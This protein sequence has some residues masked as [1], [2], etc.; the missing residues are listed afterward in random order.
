MSLNCTTTCVCPVTG[1]DYISAG[2]EDRDCKHRNINVERRGRAHQSPWQFLIDRGNGIESPAHGN[3]REKLVLDRANLRRMISGKASTCEAY[4][5]A[6]ESPISRQ[7]PA[8]TSHP[9]AAA[10]RSRSDH[11]RLSAFSYVSR[12]SLDSP[13]LSMVD[14]IGHSRPPLD[15]QRR[16]KAG[17]FQQSHKSAIKVK[18][19]ESRR[20]VPLGGKQSGII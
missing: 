17:G 11:R 3:W 16:H 20:Y 2:Y 5:V 15:R 13:E 12:A 19:W 6:R 10:G 4:G 18:Q 7:P 14:K 1:I 8:F 9:R